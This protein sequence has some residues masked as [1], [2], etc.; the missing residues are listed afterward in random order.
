MY[1]F[2]TQPRFPT[3][4]GHYCIPSTS[5]TSTISTR[6]TRVTR[7]TIIYRLL[8]SSRHVPRCLVC[9]GIVIVFLATRCRV[10]RPTPLPCHRASRSDP[11]LVLLSLMPVHSVAVIPRWVKFAATTAPPP[12]PMLIST[13][14]VVSTTASPSTA[15]P[16]RRDVATRRKLSQLIVSVSKVATFPEPTFPVLPPERNERTIVA[17][18]ECLRTKACR[19]RVGRVGRVGRVVS[20]HPGLPQPRAAAAQLDFHERKNKRL[21]PGRHALAAHQSSLWLPVLTSHTRIAAKSAP[22]RVEPDER[23]SKLDPREFPTA[24]FHSTYRIQILVFAFSS[25]PRN[26]RGRARP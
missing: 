19:V 5:R 7:V 12:I 25:V 17:S 9:L 13:F 20:G 10:L 1:N 26:P 6:V 18:A 11:C 16:R 24:P 23:R 2:Y 14:T 8:E 15:T 3:S 21:G 4:Q 22:W